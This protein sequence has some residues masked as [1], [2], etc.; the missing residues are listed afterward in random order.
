MQLNPSVDSIFEFTF[1]D[2][3]L[4]NYEPHPHIAATVAV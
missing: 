2:F 4:L 3:T 1:G